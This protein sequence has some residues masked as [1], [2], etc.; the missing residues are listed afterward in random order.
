VPG[1]PPALS[2]ASPPPYA[3]YASYASAGLPAG[4]HRLRI[5]PHPPSTPAHTAPL[6]PS[7][8]SAEGVLDSKKNSTFIYSHTHEGTSAGIEADRI[9]HTAHSSP[10]PALTHTHKPAPAF[11]LVKHF[12]EDGGSFLLF[13]PGDHKRYKIVPGLAPLL[14]SPY[15]PA[16][17]PSQASG[18][19]PGLGSMGL[20][21]VG[22]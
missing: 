15:E 11:S 1:L 10:I 5:P 18:S 16:Y 20:P 12:N 22:V 6:P 19:A 7:A 2:S 3:T 13:S 9:A 21:K 8:S 4:R 17:Q 14:L